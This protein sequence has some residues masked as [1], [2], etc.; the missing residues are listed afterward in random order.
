MRCSLCTEKAVIDHPARCEKHFIEGFEER[1]WETVERF[2]LIKENERICVAASGGKDSLALLHVLS[3]RHPIEALAVDEGIPGYR[4]KTLEDLR[5]FC[6]E[7]GIPLRVVTFEDLGAKPLYAQD[8]ERPCATCGVLR[9]KALLSHNTADLIATGHNLD[10]ECQ[11][12]LM[13][14][15]RN[16]EHL[17][18]RLGPRTAPN[19]RMAARIKPFYLT[20]EREVRAYCLLKGITTNFVE[21]PNAAESFR[22]RVNEALARL[23]AEK[24]GSKRRIV[25][26]FLSQRYEDGR[27]ERTCERCG[28]P[29]SGKL[30]KACTL[31]TA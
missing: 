11:N 6:D 20:P 7:R 28:G 10:D 15:L 13:N 5:R 29:A 16:N 8:L 21:C 3:Q 1:V 22:W 19:K 4:E 26:R 23:E 18:A 31:V 24:P 2:E 14:L 9:R 25:E 30:C 17:L 12:I 27:I